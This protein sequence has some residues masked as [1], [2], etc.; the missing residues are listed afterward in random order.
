MG[1]VLQKAKQRASLTKMQEKVRQVLL[2]LLLIVPQMACPTFLHK[3]QLNLQA[4]H[5]L[6]LRDVSSILNVF[7]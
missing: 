2:A 7:F 3:S 1:S 5:R 4:G 6:Q